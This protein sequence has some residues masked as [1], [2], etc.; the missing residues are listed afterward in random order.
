MS[1]RSARRIAI[2]GGGVNVSSGRRGLADARGRAACP[3]PTRNQASTSAGVGGRARS[4]SGSSRRPRPSG[5]AACRTGRGSPR[6]VGVDGVAGALDPHVR[7][8]RRVPAAPRQVADDRAAA[9]TRPHRTRP[10]SATAASI[11]ARAAAVV[12]VVGRQA[13]VRPAAGPGGARARRRAASSM[14]SAANGRTDRANSKHLG[15]WVG[16]QEPRRPMVRA[17]EHPRA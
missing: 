17:R 1:R 9:P 2:P 8:P 4:R 3:K 7:T 10:G 5:A 12:L 13:Q 11:A 16:R 14:W 15:R 6:V